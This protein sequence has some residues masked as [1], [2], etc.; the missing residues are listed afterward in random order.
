MVVARRLVSRIVVLL[1]AL[2]AFGCGGGGTET[3]IPAPTPTPAPLLAATSYANFKQ[4]G[5]QPHTLPAG[6]NTSR[7]YGNFAGNGRLD[8]FR[9]TLTYT[10]QRP[11][12]D[13]TLG[14]FEFF[15]RQVDGTYVRNDELL[16]DSTGC[17][18]PRKAI[19]ADFNGDRRP[20]VFVACHGYDA[21]PFPGERN[22]VVLSQPNGKY[23][24]SD[25][26]IDIGFF[27]GATAADL[28]GDGKV[29]VMLVNNFDP[30]KALVLLNDGSGKFTREAASRV[31]ASIRSKGGYFSVE[32]IDLNDD[33]LLD[34]FLGGHEYEGAATN[35][36]L[37]PGSNNFSAV[38]PILVPAVVNEGVVLDFTM[39]GSGTS[40]TVW[41]VRTS[42]GDGSFYN[43]RVIQKVAYPSLSSSIVLNTR[44]SR[45]IPWIIPAEVDG[46]TMITSDN[47][48]DTIHIPQ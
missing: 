19:V 10:P 21:P 2:S 18:H 3:P 16:S 20:D 27:H 4:I 35:I 5:L 47:R 36:F 44:T 40:K 37:N 48:A 34:L 46:A 43:S 32:L 13:A 31:P 7:A 30:N 9:A 12:A 6:D 24:V 1:A 15:S 22:K 26:A 38:T 45:W 33:G 23:L 11:Q 17:M 8:L 41:I 29:D 39:T 28:N 42:G 14:R 25:A